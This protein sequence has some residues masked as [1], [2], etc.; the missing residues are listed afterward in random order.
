[1]AEPGLR[2]T[3]PRPATGRRA[4]AIPPPSARLASRFA[5]AFTAGDVDGVVALLTDDAWL[6]MPP[7]PHEYVGRAAIAGFLRTSS[8]WRGPRGLHLVPTRANGQP[9]FGC[10]VVGEPDEHRTYPFSVVVL[11]MSGDRIS[12]ITRF[13]DP[14]LLRAFGLTDRA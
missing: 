9:A 14:D 6:A 5:E 4:A 1:M 8:D 13:L 7:A 3:A 11:T 2:A 12:A 10:F